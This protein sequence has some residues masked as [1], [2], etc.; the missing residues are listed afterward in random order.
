MIGRTLK[1]FTAT[2]DR[3]ALSLQLE[4]V[5]IKRS[6]TFERSLC[7]G[8]Q[9]RPSGDVGD[10]AGEGKEATRLNHVE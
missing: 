4:A 7:S 10:Q 1:G 3:G 8:S 5:V 9:R 2:A 6:Y